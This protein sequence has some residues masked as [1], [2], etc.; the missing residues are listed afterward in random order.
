MSKVKTITQDKLE[1]A[2]YET[3][4]AWDLSTLITF[5]LDAMIAEAVKEDY[6][7]VSKYDGEQAR[8]EYSTLSGDDSDLEDDQTLY[9]VTV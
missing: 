3:I 2:M 7:V 1:E 9:R 8:Y 5:A 6:A 4:D